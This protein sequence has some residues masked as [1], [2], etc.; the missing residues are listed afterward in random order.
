MTCA[1]GCLKKTYRLHVHLVFWSSNHAPALRVYVLW[2]VW[3]MVVHTAIGPCSI[4]TATGCVYHA[5]P[6]CVDFPKQHTG[7]LWIMSYGLLNEQYNLPHTAHNLLWPVTVNHVF[8]TVS[9]DVQENQYP[10]YYGR[11]PVN[12]GEASAG[13]YVRTQHPWIGSVIVYRG[14]DANGRFIIVLHAWDGPI[15]R[16]GGPCCPTTVATCPAGRRS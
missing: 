8:Y 2:P 14:D 7:P 12:Y 9:K 1:P 11:Q 5:A 3:I 13:P 4:A 15:P 10:C 6:R 16:D